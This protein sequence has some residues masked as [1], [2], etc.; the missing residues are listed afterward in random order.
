[1]FILVMARTPA[2]LY[3]QYPSNC[4]VLIMG[5]SDPINYNLKEVC[6]DENA[7]VLD[8]DDLLVNMVQNI[9]DR[10]FDFMDDIIDVIDNILDDVEDDLN[11]LFMDDIIGEIQDILNEIGEN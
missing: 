11:G 1:M 8:G 7:V 6:G 9:G 2:V 4:R 5:Y 10:E 3:S